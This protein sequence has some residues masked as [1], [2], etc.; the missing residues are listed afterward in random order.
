MVNLL[1]SIQYLYMHICNL[2]NK[3]SDPDFWEGIMINYHFQVWS[4]LHCFIQM[5]PRGACLRGCI[6]TLVAFI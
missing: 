5:T 6:V 1:K 3:I 4:F 2:E